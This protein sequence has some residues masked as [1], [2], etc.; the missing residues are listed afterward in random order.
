MLF[1][2]TLW[3]RQAHR[4]E[5]MR[6]LLQVSHQMAPQWRSLAGAVPSR[7]GPVSA[8]TCHKLLCYTLGST[9]TYYDIL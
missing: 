8:L 6:R 4:S 7:E 9:I 1:I 3:K 2:V 5:A